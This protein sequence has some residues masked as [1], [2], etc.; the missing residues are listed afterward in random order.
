MISSPSSSPRAGA[1]S[2]KG[3]GEMFRA[4]IEASDDVFAVISTER[5][6]LY[7]SPSV[8]RLLGYEPCEL[9]GC[10]YLRR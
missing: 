2:S 1:P 10:V 5:G 3:G 8:Q 4:L 6:F 7:L 9:L